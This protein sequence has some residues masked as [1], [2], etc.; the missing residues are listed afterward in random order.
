MNCG[1]LC[2]LICSFAILFI[3]I[4]IINVFEFFEYVTP[5][6]NSYEPEW[7]EIRKIFSSETVYFN[8]VC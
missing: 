5:H 7:P 1:K 8:I 4:S 2:K 3:F 6:H